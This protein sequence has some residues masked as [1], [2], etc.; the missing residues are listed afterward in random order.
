MAIRKRVSANAT[1]RRR[2]LFGLFE[3]VCLSSAE[4]GD[5]DLYQDKHT[6]NGTFC[7][8]AIIVHTDL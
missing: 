8:K 4:R 6:P 2:F 1:L 3:G 7:V 5:A